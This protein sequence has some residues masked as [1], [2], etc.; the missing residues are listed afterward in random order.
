[1]ESIQG[2]ILPRRAA[3]STAIL[4]L[5]GIRTAS[6]ESAVGTLPAPIEGT[7]P[8]LDRI[9]TET[10]QRTGVPGLAVAVVHQDRVIHLK[11]F[12]VRVAGAPETVDPDTVFPLASVSKPIASTVMAA[13]VGDGVIGWDDP[14]TQHFPAFEMF[15]PWPTRA[16]TLRDMFAHRSGLPHHAGD[17]LE[18]IG[19]DR[20]EI[21]H[22]LRYQKPG[23]SFRSEYAYTNFGLTAAATAA[24]MASGQSWEDL[25]RD[26]VYSPAGMTRT[27]SSF[28]QFAA[29][30]NRVHSH[31]MQGDAW[32]AKYTRDADAQTPAGGVSSSVRDMANWMRLQLGQGTFEGREIVKAA[33]LAETHRPQ[34]VNNPPKDPTA[35]RAG[36]YGLGWN[37][38]YGD[39]EGVRWGHS[40]AFNL[41]AA[42]NVLLLPG[43]QLGIAVLTNAQPIGV[44][45]AVSQSFVD[46]ALTGKVQRDWLGFLGPIFKTSM[47][48]DYGTT[49]DYSK[50]PQPPTPP[51]P[52]DTYVDRYRND[53]FGEILIATTND[54]WVLKLGPK[55]TAFPM[56]HFDRDTFTY[57]PVGEN[58]YGPSAVTFMVG[59]NR[60]AVSVTVENLDLNGQGIFFRTAGG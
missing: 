21:L 40:G 42:T 13:L 36:F 8:E 17:A 31:V 53:L 3:I 30:T 25:S 28:A 50:P 2:F 24:A 60:K 54:G 14:I 47:A 9:V 1:M 46:L 56:R 18:D 34:I 44:A 43:H 52:A 7:L 49:T 38:G 37:V 23:S 6:A 35:D 55:Q 29:A 59:A 27:S 5:L 48:P 11:G 20:T 15:D 57:Q 45:E 19:F 4:G 10:M 16:V 39:Q 12:G 33:A 26:R 22:R 41:G 32:I 58:A 51:L